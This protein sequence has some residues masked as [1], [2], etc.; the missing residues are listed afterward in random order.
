MHLRRLHH[1]A[2]ASLFV[3]FGRV[4]YRRHSLRLRLNALRL[5]H[6][7]T[8]STYLRR[9]SRSLLRKSSMDTPPVPTT[10]DL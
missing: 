6:A 8:V 9:A 3:P 10:K 1:K 7:A 5:S 2:L 4:I